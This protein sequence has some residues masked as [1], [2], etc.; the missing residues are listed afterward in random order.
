MPA[1]KQT[2]TEEQEA[3][4]QP[5]YRWGDRLRCYNCCDGYHHHSWLGFGC[6]LLPR[7]PSKAQ[8]PP[9]TRCRWLDGHPAALIA[10]LEALTAW[11]TQRVR[12]LVNQLNAGVSAARR[13]ELL[14]ELNEIVPLHDKDGCLNP[15]KL[16]ILIVARE[17]SYLDWKIRCWLLD[18]WAA[19]AIAERMGLLSAVLDLLC[20]KEAADEEEDFDNDDEEPVS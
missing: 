18:D 5:L 17:L 2:N 7:S 9:R 3:I 20:A 1:S 16:R 12:L 8:A 4:I 11:E 13:S 15:L 14:D 6:L 19:I 10:V